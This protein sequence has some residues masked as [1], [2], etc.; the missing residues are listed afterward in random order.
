[1]TTIHDKKRCRHLPAALLVMY[2]Q[3]AELPEEWG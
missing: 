2:D 1:M 3:I